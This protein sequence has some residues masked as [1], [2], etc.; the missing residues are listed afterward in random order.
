MPKGRIASWWTSVLG[1]L[2]S[3]QRRIWWTT[4]VLVTA[5]G[6]LWALANPLFAAPDENSHVVRAVALDH[7]QLT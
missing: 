7:G 6:G 5:V 3:S 2:G 1:S 4:F